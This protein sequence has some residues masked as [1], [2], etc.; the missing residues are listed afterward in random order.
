MRE[1]LR[2]QRGELRQIRI[3]HQWR[4]EREP[5]LR[6]WEMPVQMVC[7]AYFSWRWLAGGARFRPWSLRYLA[8]IAHF[9]SLSELAVRASLANRVW[10]EADAKRRGMK[11]KDDDAPSV[12]ELL[13]RVVERYPGGWIRMVYLPCQ[14]WSVCVDLPGHLEAVEAT[15]GTL[16]NALTKLLTV[17]LPPGTNYD[18][19]VVD[20]GYA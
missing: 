1:W 17:E 7:A 19:H 2:K 13:G 9:S 18:A 12:G 6:W 3:N 4:K 16:Q 8:W 14:M 15:A 5:G 11:F 10:A 20:G